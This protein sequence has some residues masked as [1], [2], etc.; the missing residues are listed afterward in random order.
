MRAARWSTA[1]AAL[2][3]K[4]LPYPG[5]GIA[6]GHQA[7]ML[8]VVTMLSAAW[9]SVRAET[10]RKGF[11]NTT[12]SP[13][14]SPPATTTYSPPVPTAEEVV[15]HDIDEICELLEGWHLPAEI[16]EALK[17]SPR[18]PPFATGIPRA[19]QDVLTILPYM[20]DPTHTKQQRKD[21]VRAW[22]F[23]EDGDDIF[24][25]ELIADIKKE[26]K[27][28]HPHTTST[29]P[30]LPLPRDHSANFENI[31]GAMAEYCDEQQHPEWA[32]LSPKQQFNKVLEREAELSKKE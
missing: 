3:Y 26:Y 28:T 9:R 11:I 24:K 20:Q 27:D 15:E 23:G 17:A 29:E 31:V 32:Q 8:E 19:L 18:P 16:E 22:I 5:H 30:S 25:S 14:W 10:I 12:L 7:N 13:T 1:G 6:T 2:I 4:A 21:A